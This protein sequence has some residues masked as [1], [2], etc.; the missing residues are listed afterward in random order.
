MF[1]RN[2]LETV[3][4]CSRFLK[5]ASPRAGI[6]TALTCWLATAGLA[7][8]V[9]TGLDRAFVTPPPS[10]RPWVYWYFM[11]GNLSQEGMT[12]DL[13]AMKKAGTSGYRAVSASS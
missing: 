13:E 12:A 10:A 7:L 1:A 4:K 11:D 3:K 2:Q 8:G 6:K 5:S 9:E